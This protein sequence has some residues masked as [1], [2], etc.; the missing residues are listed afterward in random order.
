MDHVLRVNNKVT[1]DDSIVQY[2]LHTHIPYSPQTLDNND[3]IRIPIH[4]TNVYTLPSKSFLYIEV[5]VPEVKIKGTDGKDTVMNVKLVNN[6]MAFLFDEIRYEINGTTVDKTKNVGITTTMKNLLS[7][8]ESE[9]NALANAGWNVVGDPITNGSASTY[10]YC[11]PLRLLLGFAEDF[12]KILLNVKQDLVLIRSSADTNAVLTSQ[13]ANV[14]LEVTKVQWKV[15]YVYV[16]EI[17]RLGLLKLLENDDAL[18]M[19]F[20]TWQ[21]HEYPGL[22]Q[23]T[24][25]TWNVKTTSQLE[26]PRFVALAFQTARKN[27]VTKDCSKFDH[28]GLY[29]VRLYLNENYY[30]YDNLQGSTKLMYEMFAG[31]RP[32][33]YNTDQVDTPISP[34]KFITDFPV[35]L[36]DCSRQ[37]ESLKTGAVDIRLEFE[38]KANVPAETIAYCLIIYDTIVEYTP[39][40]GSVARIM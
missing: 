3:E 5:K 23:T 35:V 18:A 29:N 38:T 25:H 2:D 26:K 7:L 20:R 28:C 11:V 17:Y 30:P 8:R 33:Y 31:F 36:I 27:D 40:S 13:K 22:K 24:S 19:P 39:L 9:K 6:A 10:T 4:Q 1:L 15:P 32:I 14:N 21:L 37:D 16:S 12:D 34:E